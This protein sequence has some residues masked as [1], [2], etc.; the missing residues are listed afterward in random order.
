MG[1]LL[2]VRHGQADTSGDTYDK[3]TPR[4]VEQARRLGEFWSARSMQFDRVY[5]GPC[6]RHEQTFEAV[7]AA[8][9]T[10]SQTMPEP[11]STEALDELPAIELTKRAAPELALRDPRV[12]GWLRAIVQGQDAARILPRLI[13]HV[14]RLYAAGELAIEG[15]ETFRG[16]RERVE[17]WLSDEVLRVARGA[18][19]VAFTSGGPVGVAVGCALELTDPKIIDV[20]GMVR[21]ASYSEFR[22]DARRLS[23]VSFNAHPHLQDD[24]LTQI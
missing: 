4:G 22:F 3:L 5:V 21:N 16:F 11:I 14:T 18:R 15:L 20:I 7:R 9:M 2:L 1:T 10:E 12:A 19:V 23:M 6:Q 8:Y 17:R 24:W 13:E